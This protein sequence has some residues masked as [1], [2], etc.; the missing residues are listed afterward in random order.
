MP[1]SIPIAEPV[2]S[3]AVADGLARLLGPVSLT[4]RQ[5]IPGRHGAVELLAPPVTPPMQPGVIAAVG[6]L[7]QAA[8]RDRE[9]LERVQAEAA[10]SPKDVADAVKILTRARGR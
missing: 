6:V 1:F 7:V 4:V 9:T 8:K 3:I 10:P 2:D 5:P